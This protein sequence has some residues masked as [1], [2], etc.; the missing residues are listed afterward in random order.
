[1]Q[2]VL[3]LLVCEQQEEPLA[4]IVGEEQGFGLE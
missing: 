4:E 3:A 1:M 2:I